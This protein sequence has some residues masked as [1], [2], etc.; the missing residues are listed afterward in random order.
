MNLMYLKS[1]LVLLITFI[2]FR[3]SYTF[4]VNCF[5]FR[6][7][8]NTRKITKMKKGQILNPCTTFL[9]CWLFYVFAGTWDAAILPL[10]LISCT[11]KYYRTL[12]G[13]KLSQSLL[14]TVDQS[15]QWRT[16]GGGVGVFKP[17]LKFRKPFKI[18]PNSTRLWKLLK[19]A[20]FRMPT[21]QD[22]RKKRQ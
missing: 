8:F 13:C 4:W 6:Q 7:M 21:P 17:P 14:D 15:Y 18:V 1:H 9:I 5:D 20:E 3:Y 10:V 12:E 22:V 2:S 19:I 11:F 16:E